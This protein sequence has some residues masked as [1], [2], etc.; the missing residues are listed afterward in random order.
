M[1]PNPV[2]RDGKVKGSA[3]ARALA[4]FFKFLAA[5]LWIAG[6]IVLFTALSGDFGINLPRDF[7]NLIDA[8]SGDNILVTGIAWLIVGFVLYGIGELIRLLNIVRRNTRL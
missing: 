4:A 1:P 5:L 8:F 3:G 2:I 7:T 6:A